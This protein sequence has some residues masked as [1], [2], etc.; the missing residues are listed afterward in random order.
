MYKAVKLFL[1]VFLEDS[2][3]LKFYGY[4]MAVVRTVSR[5]VEF[6]ATV[7]FILTIPEFGT[8]ALWA[9]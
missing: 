1:G 4:V 9:I 3:E 8:I 2:L 6:A 5:Q 7:F